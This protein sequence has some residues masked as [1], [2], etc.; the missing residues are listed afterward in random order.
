MTH[1]TSHS[2][3]LLGVYGIAQNLS[4]SVCLFGTSGRMGMF[5]SCPMQTQEA[6]R[7]CASVFR[8]RDHITSLNIPLAEASCRFESNIEQ[9]RKYTLPSLVGGGVKSRGKKQGSNV[10]QQRE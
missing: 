9:V 10:L 7:N 2:F 1:S 8:A 3:F 4:L 6:K 5:H